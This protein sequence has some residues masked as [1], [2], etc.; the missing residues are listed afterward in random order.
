MG[1]PAI[2]VDSDDGF[3]RAG[4]SPVVVGFFVFVDCFKKKLLLRNWT[5]SLR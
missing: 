4:S 3:G 2:I 5:I 1:H